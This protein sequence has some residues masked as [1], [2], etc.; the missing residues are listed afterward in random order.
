MVAIDVENNDGQGV[1]WAT[2]TPEPSRPCSPEMVC[3]R[4][5]RFQ[6]KTFVTIMLRFRVNV[7]KGSSNLITLRTRQ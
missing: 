7:P 5:I 1:E 6:A 2:Y 3:L 4:S